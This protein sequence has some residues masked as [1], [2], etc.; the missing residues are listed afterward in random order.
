MVLYVQQVQRLLQITTPPLVVI[1]GRQ[2]GSPQPAFPGPAAPPWLRGFL[3][4]AVCCRNFGWLQGWINNQVI[5]KPQGIV[6]LV[7]CLW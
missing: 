3:L 6:M 4:L 1:T 5:A 7:R 2:I